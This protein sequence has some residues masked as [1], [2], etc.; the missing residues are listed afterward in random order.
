MPPHPCEH[1]VLVAEQ[2]GELAEEQVQH[3]C[4]SDELGELSAFMSKSKQLQPR[5]GGKSQQG[6]PG[7]REREAVGVSD[8]SGGANW[9]RNWTPEERAAVAMAGDCLPEL[10]DSRTQVAGKE[11]E[12]RAPSL[13][14]ERVEKAQ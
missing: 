7:T 3:P 14:G 13:T 4:H 12:G 2:H 6:C 10:P 8:S 5:R 11:D 1:L 9:S